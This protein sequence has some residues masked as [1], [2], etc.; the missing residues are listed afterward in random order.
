MIV[1]WRPFYFA[2]CATSWLTVSM[3]FCTSSNSMK[4]SNLSQPFSF[5]TKKN[6]KHGLNVFVVK[7]AQGKL[8]SWFHLVK[9]FEVW[10]SIWKYRVGGLSSLIEAIICFELEIK[11]G[12][13]HYFSRK[14]TCCYNYFTVHLNE[15]HLK[16]MSLSQNTDE[17]I[18]CLLCFRLASHFKM[19]GYPKE[20]DWNHHHQHFLF[21]I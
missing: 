7:A 5:R 21:K 8:C 6:L 18:D 20:I 19:M 11:T 10:D 17:S 3:M 4:C 14:P 15:S 13:L 2:F 16:R 12:F 1:K 9:Q